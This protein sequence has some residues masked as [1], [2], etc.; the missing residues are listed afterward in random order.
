MIVDDPSSLAAL[1][2][3]LAGARRVAL[4][5]EADGMHAFRPKARVAQLAWE[6]GRAVEV[7]VVDLMAVEPAG[8]A[9]LFASGTPKILHDL[10]FDCQL[11]FAEGLVLRSVVDTQILA[12]MLGRP[13]LGLASLLGER[14]IAVDKELQHH[15]WRVRPFTEAHV[16]Y[17]E[18]DVRHLFRLADELAAE[19]S[20][21]GLDEEVRVET[22]YRIS[23]SEV[24]PWADEIR[25][26]GEEKLSPRARPVC[27]RLALYR[28]AV[29]REWDVPVHRVMSAE[30]VLLL[31]ERA[32][33]DVHAVKRLVRGRAAG[34]SVELVEVIRAAVA[35]PAES[36]PSAPRPRRADL[37]QS[38]AADQRL[39]AWRK[40]EA[41]RRAVSEQ[42][43]LPGHCV[44][45]LAAALPADLAGLRRIPGLGEVRVTRDGA[46]LLACLS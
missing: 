40:A 11:L 17:L 25:V 9:S 10:G 20:A 39:R 2:E 33:L 41:T 7:A 3:R 24:L 38:R 19:V 44:S 21:A 5:L 22:L 32:P 15:D 34:L 27:R 29:A 45:D 37:Q 46:A 6:E 26:K 31:A 4:D 28:E 18:G 14:G 1:G 16:A 30:V 23:T 12:K 13:Q 36:A 35:E 8:F 42:A 43:V